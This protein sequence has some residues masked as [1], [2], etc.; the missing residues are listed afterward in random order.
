MVI[1]KLLLNRAVESFNVSIHLRCPRIGVIVGDLKL[2]QFDREVFLPLT[3]VIGEN[4]G[5]GIGKEQTESGE[6]LSGR[7]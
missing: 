6:E 5:D 2:E 1:E 3:P 4:K 7:L